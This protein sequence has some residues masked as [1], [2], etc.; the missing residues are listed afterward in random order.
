MVEVGLGMA[1]L[2]MHGRVDFRVA[3]GDQQPADERREQIEEHP[4]EDRDGAEDG[5]REP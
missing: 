4:K 2:A 3:I 1:K 5:R